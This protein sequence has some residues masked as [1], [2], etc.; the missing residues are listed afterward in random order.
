MDEEIGLKVLAEQ[1][2]GVRDELAGLREEAAQLRSQMEHARQEL[3]DAKKDGTRPFH[4]NEWW[5]SLSLIQELQ[6]LVEKLRPIVRE[7]G[8]VV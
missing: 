5:A 7:R 8:N 1:V 3:A 4:A 2:A 6:A